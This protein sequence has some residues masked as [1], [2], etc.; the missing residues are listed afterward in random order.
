MNKDVVE[1]T[2]FNL[3]EDK[4][5]PNDCKIFFKGH[6]LLCSNVSWFLRTSDHRCFHWLENWVSC[7]ASDA[8]N[9]HLNKWSDDHTHKKNI[10]YD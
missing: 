5:D 9:K 7:E 6:C 2:L 1:L 3:N 8:L 4:T 10:H